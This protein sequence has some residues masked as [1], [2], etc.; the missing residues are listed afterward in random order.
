MRRSKNSSLDHLVGADEQRRW[1]GN[2]ERL[3]GLRLITSSNL[4]G[5]SNPDVG[6]LD[7]SKELDDLSGKKL[8]NE[9]NEARSVG[10]KAAFLR[11]FGPL[12][13]GRQTQHCDA[14]HNELTI[15]EEHR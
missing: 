1:Y 10:G 4:V 5:C 3:R 2:A 8:L 13:D 15:G 14:V 9:R 6:D 12:I 7:A 11:R